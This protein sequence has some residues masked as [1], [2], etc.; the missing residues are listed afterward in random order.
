M[1]IVIG[2]LGIFNLDQII[3]LVKTKISIV[4]N[5][6]YDKC[7]IQNN[8]ILKCS[9]FIVEGSLLFRTSSQIESL[10][11]EIIEQQEYLMKLT[12]AYEYLLQEKYT[13]NEKIIDRYDLIINTKSCRE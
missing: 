13:R 3:N 4:S 11:I 10:R 9:Q 8:L 12:D 1:S 6:I 5:Q 2:K 7:Q